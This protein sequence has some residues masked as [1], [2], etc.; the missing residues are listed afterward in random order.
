MKKQLAALSVLSALSQ[1]SG[2]MVTVG[3]SNTVE[4]LAALPFEVICGNGYVVDL[5]DTDEIFAGYISSDGKGGLVFLVD[6]SDSDKGPYSAGS[7]I[8]LDDL[9]RLSHKASFK[10]VGYYPEEI[11]TY[12]RPSSG[13]KEIYSMNRCAEEGIISEENSAAKGSQRSDLGH[14]DESPAPPW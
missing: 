4:S 10:W 14:A 2:G 3:R 5:A 9:V 6:E 13:A 11:M 8:L 7:A 12:M 1:T